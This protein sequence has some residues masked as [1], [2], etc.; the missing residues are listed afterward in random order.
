MRVQLID[1]VIRFW[2]WWLG[3][4][5][6]CLPAWLRAAF[7]R[8]R[9][10]L[11]VTIADGQAAFELDKGKVSTTLGRLDLG[12]G[13][14]AEERPEVR[15]IV[16]RARAASTPVSLELPPD[17]ILRRIVE[18]PSAAAENLREV[19]A[20]EM[21]RHTPFKVAEVY[22]DYRLV[23]TDRRQKRIRVDLVVASKAVVDRELAILRAWDLDPDRI[24]PTGDDG[25]DN[26]RFNLLPASAARDEGAVSRWLSAG[27]AVAACL[28]LAVAVYLPLSKKQ[29]VLAVSQA[30][31]AEARAEAVAADAL[32]QRVG[33]MAARGRFV[34]EQKRSKPTVTELLA[35]VTRLLPDHTWIMQ[36]VWR[37][38]GLRLSGYSAKPSSL[39]GLLE[40][41]EL[42]AEVKFN[43]PVTM[44]SRVGLER[45]N[46][47]AKVPGR[48]GE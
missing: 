11:A 18:L 12:A 21:D 20:F 27:F 1:I 48:G 13:D 44:D 24:G 3:E 14:P 30:R 41:S 10:H 43:S 36:F 46:V 19:L 6:A 2:R 33:E 42:L 32:K 37:D 40:Q 28:L 23:A 31:L 38:D 29:E 15:R 45:F 39:I 26:N 22:F 8:R 34:V 4:L 16:R 17:K 47:S 9:R 25:A 35:E 5:A 7:G